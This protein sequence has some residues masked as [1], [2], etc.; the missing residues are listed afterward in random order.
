[1]NSQ[2]YQEQT[3]RTDIE[4]YSGPM[5]RIKINKKTIHNALKGFMISSSA[6]DIM[7][8]KVMYD[9]NPLKLMEL[10]AEYTKILKMF[11]NDQ[12]LDKIAEAAEAQQQ[13]GRS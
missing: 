8:K 1:M 10:D 6:L 2:D 4:D 7:K 3:R 5:E 11:E 12:Y 13:R 9:S